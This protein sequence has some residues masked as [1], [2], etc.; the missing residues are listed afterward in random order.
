MKLK[1]N[2]LVASQE[3]LEHLVAEKVPASLAFKISRIVQKVNVELRGYFKARRTLLHRLGT[4]TA[5]KQY[6][7]IPEQQ[8]EF[9]NEMIAL[10][11]IEIELSFMPILEAD[12]PDLSPTDATA[13]WWLVKTENSE[14]EQK[15]E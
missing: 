7:V 10:L 11:D 3:A 14:E 13:L 12:L 4:P 2:D 1:L 8:P 15:G 5:D 6:R 9:I